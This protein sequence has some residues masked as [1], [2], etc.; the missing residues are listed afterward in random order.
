MRITNIDQIQPGKTYFYTHVLGE[1]SYVTPYTVSRVSDDGYG[2][3][4]HYNE[5]NSLGKS[6]VERFS[7]VDCSAYRD[8]QENGYNRHRLFD[9]LEEA[10][11]YI[12]D[13]ST[14]EAY[15]ED[16]KNPYHFSNIDIDYFD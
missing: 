9:N 1:S 5:T 11:D 12:Y 3:W 7:L 14:L 13:P 6:V 10:E 8:G 16:K 15:A 4:A 2:G